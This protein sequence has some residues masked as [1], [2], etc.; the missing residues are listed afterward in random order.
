MIP[1]EDLADM[2][3]VRPVIDRLVELHTL[4]QELRVGALLAVGRWEDSLA[5]L[6]GLVAAHPGRERLWE[7]LMR[8]RWMAGRPAEALET[9][10]RARDALLAFGLEPGVRLRHLEHEILVDDTDVAAVP[11]VAPRSPRSTARPRGDTHLWDLVGRQEVL[12]RFP[13]VVT[14]D[15]PGL[16]L[17]GEAGVGKTRLLHECALLAGA[18]ATRTVSFR[19]NE[20]L[21]T[22]P[23]GVA[24]SL[25]ALRPGPLPAQ[26]QQ[27]LGAL[28]SLRTSTPPIVLVDDVMHLDG[29]TLTLLTAA[30]EAGVARVVATLRTGEPVPP[31]VTR[32]WVD[33][34]L[35]RLHLD[36]LARDEM[37]AL[38]DAAVGPTHPGTRRRLAEL[39]AGN[40]L[41]LREVVRAGRDERALVLAE[42]GRWVLESDVAGAGRLTELVGASVNRLGD[43][44]RRAFEVV[45][46]VRP[47]ALVVLEDIVDPGAVDE[48]E[49]RHLVRVADGSAGPVVDVTHPLHAEN[50]AAGLT[51]MRR[52]ALGLQ[53]SEALQARDFPLEGDLLRAATLQLAH[54]TLDPDLA[55]A[56]SEQAVLRLDPALALR[57]AEV[58]CAA[59]PDDVHVWRLCGRAAHHGGRHDEAD[60]HLARAQ[61]LAEDPDDQVAVASERAANLGFGARDPAAAIAVL[62]PAIARLG[63]HPATGRLRV[64]RALFLGM[65]GDLREVVAASGALVDDDLAPVD[66]LSIA[67]SVTLARS[68]LGQLDG[69]LATTEEQLPH[70]RELRPV[71]PLA[72]SQLQV[73]R[74]SALIC[75]GRVGDA[76][77]I[78][79]RCHAASRDDPGTM[80]L[81][82]TFLLWV[83][84]A[85]GRLG[86]GTRRARELG[87]RLEGSDPL[88]M[89]LLWPGWS[90]IHLAQT[91]HADAARRHLAAG[92]R[93]AALAEPRSA[94]WWGR[95]EAWLLL[96]DT[97][98]A[99]A[100]L[101]DV[102]R[103]AVADD[104]VTWGMAALYDAVRLGRAAAVVE[105]LEAAGRDTRGATL[106]DAFCASAR[107]HARGDMDA[108][109]VVAERF[110]DQGADLL[111]AEAW[112]RVAAGSEGELAQRGRSRARTLAAGVGASTP[113][114]SHVL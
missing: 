112:C 32:W 25:G 89:H 10:R 33:L 95:A 15:L 74:C 70:A 43:A 40:P 81:W 24:G 51:A 67:V 49:S 107:A 1:Y 8:A 94:V 18:H 63:E 96:P 6:E 28:A 78:T 3:T 114:L 56:A 66:R 47:I 93:E 57:L 58:A 50:V 113:A 36:G 16:V 103:S 104:H 84:E 55:V 34:G 26:V 54:G 62:E 91:G 100:R 42:D 20:S 7:Q 98:A 69:V 11:L 64:E 12:A 85:A 72:E 111:A 79:R 101:L 52:R 41:H 35:D 88:G 27:L 21:A 82:D 17:A 14:G 61:E 87:P 76:L 9:Y 75:A 45:A 44:A 80:L 22:L 48:L 86:E 110:A 53:V 77:A 92:D 19:A 37:H 31:A 59:R 60:R 5:D 105:A 13:E 68:M 30:L 83:L 73:N 108:L 71:L 38:I 90:A 97:D 102:G 39:A 29:A 23:L 4:A 2:A 106:L 109:A 46:V 65:S 99:V